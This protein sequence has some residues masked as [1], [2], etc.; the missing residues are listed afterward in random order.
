MPVTATVARVT[1]TVATVAP[2]AAV[3]AMP[4]TAAAA[5]TVTRRFA[6]TVAAALTVT[7][8]GPPIAILVMPTHPYVAM[9][10]PAD[11]VSGLTDPPCTVVL[12]MGVMATRCTIAH[13]TRPMDTRCT[14]AHSTGPM[15][16]HHSCRGIGFIDRFTLTHGTC[17]AIGMQRTGVDVRCAPRAW[18]DSETNRNSQHTIA[19][20]N[21]EPTSAVTSTALV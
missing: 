12:T 21:E 16:T 14:I 11:A 8:V 19:S 1:A 13:S 7:Q 2:A 9:A 4:V 20:T 18:L 15:D 5:L 10:T 3:T 6:A 17:P